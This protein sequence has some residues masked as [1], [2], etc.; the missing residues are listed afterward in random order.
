MNQAPETPSPV[1]DNLLSLLRG[2]MT[3]AA[4][5]EQLKSALEQLFPRFLEARDA[6]RERITS[7]GPE[8]VQKFAESI[9]RIEQAFQDVEGALNSCLEFVRSGSREDG[10]RSE[11]WLIHAAWNQATSMD[12]YQQ[13]ELAVGPTKM[14]L[15]NMLIRMKEGFVAGQYTRQEFEDSV[16]GAARMAEEAQKEIR[17]KPERNSA[18]E[19]MIEAYERLR[20]VLTDLLETA[21]LDQAMEDVIVAGESVRT[22]METLSTRILTAGPTRMQHANLVLTILAAHQAGQVQD[23]VLSKALE[24]FR[25]GMEHESAEVDRMLS[26]PTQSTAILDQVARTR[27]AYEL[28]WP[29]LELLEAYASGEADKYEPGTQALIE[30]SEALADCRAAFEQIGEIE[31]K[32]LCVKCGAPNVPDARACSKCGARMMQQSSSSS[33]MSF[34]EVGGEAR[35]ASELVMTENLHRLFEAVNAVAEENI[36]DDEFADVL[37]WMAELVQEHL[38][39]LPPAPGFSRDGMNAEQQEAVTSLEEELARHREDVTEGAEEFMTALNRLNCYLDDHDKSHLIS[40][41]QMVRDS[42]IRIQKAQR[43]IDEV[44]AS[45]EGIK[46]G[47]SPT[48][49]EEDEHEGS[50]VG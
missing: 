14:P 27:A 30:A 20:R 3:G 16:R 10:E 8:H 43:A 42:A 35:G 5:P 19:G 48:E 31:G 6:T 11:R 34:A 22:A 1:F 47:G 39:G 45:F 15:V 17:A 25:K 32:V 21:D 33:T 9:G 12:A 2:V 46:R 50:P 28:H 37:T 49:E 7:Q 23:E 4:A 38:L 24:V 29:A 36:N 26:L 18:E 44:A 13:A 40:G 41:V